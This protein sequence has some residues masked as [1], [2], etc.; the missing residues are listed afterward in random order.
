MGSGCGALA[1][2]LSSYQLPGKQKHA[3]CKCLT[4]GPALRL[5]SQGQSYLRES[6]CCRLQMWRGPETLQPQEPFHWQ[7]T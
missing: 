5:G 4:A 6:C 1:W 7:Q 2:N 3:W